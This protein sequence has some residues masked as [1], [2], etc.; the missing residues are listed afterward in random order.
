M[1][2]RKFSD[3]HIKHTDQKAQPST[4]RQIVRVDNSIRLQIDATSP[5]SS[6]SS[7]LTATPVS[8][9]PI[10]DSASTDSTP[11]Q[12]MSTALSH[13]Y[14]LTT[15]D[16][17]TNRPTVSLFLGRSLDKVSSVAIKLAAQKWFRHGLEYDSKISYRV[18]SCQ[19]NS[20][21]ASLAVI[22][23]K[24]STIFYRYKGDVIVKVHIKPFQ[25]SWHFS[26]S[27]K[28]A[29]KPVTSTFGFPGGPLPIEIPSGL[30]RLSDKKL[31]HL[32]KGSSKLIPGIR[33][34]SVT[35]SPGFLCQLIHCR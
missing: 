15:I 19:S 1:D 22:F 33:K 17:S 35:L 31:G 25:T 14:S 34:G 28:F 16:S 2:G 21:S 23:M 4:G 12:S 8:A 13:A 3:E 5:T 20:T 7:I 18:N 6:E 27:P 29:C 26:T 24:N 9:T 11:L 32:Q 10:D 30:R